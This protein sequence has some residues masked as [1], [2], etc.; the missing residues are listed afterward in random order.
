MIA[1]NCSS[2]GF[3]IGKWTDA[4]TEISSL[5]MQLLVNNKMVEQGLSSEIL[6]HPIN[7]L[8]EAARCIAESGEQLEAGQII[9][10]GAA[11]AAVALSPNQTVSVEVDT[12][13]GC[14]FT[15]AK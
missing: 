15:T 3:V 10:A 14:S 2:T 13:I 5:N 8:V 7:S 11:T 1:D 12:L 9:L 4:T 6:D